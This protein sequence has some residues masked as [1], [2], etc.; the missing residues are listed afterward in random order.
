MG[1]G[2]HGWQA[3]APATALPLL[4]AASPASRTPARKDGALR[5]SGPGG[6]LRCPWVGQAW[7]R[8]PVTSL[9]EDNQTPRLLQVICDLPWGLGCHPRPHTAALE[10]VGTAKLA[11]PKVGKLCPLSLCPCNKEH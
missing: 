11:Q 8:R 9:T 3:L 7:P 5:A 6:A 1:K 4:P 10:S 2:G